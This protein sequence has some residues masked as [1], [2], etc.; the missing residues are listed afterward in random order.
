MKKF[1]LRD[2]V[3]LLTGASSGIGAALALELGRRGARLAL[4]SRRLEELRKVAGQAQAAGSPEAIALRLDVEER[5]SCET[6]VKMATKAFDRVDC[7]VNNAG[8]HLFSQVESLPEEWLLKAFQTNVLGPMRLIQTVT[9]Q[10]RNQGSGLIVQISSTLSLRSLPEVGGYAATKA[11]LNRL[12]ESLRMELDGSGIG[13]LNVLPGV[14]TTPLRA[15]SLHP[16]PAPTDHGLPFPRT[17]ELTAREI[18]DA[19]EA[20]RR[21]LMSCAWQ[22]K[23]G[24]KWLSVIAPGFQDKRFKRINPVK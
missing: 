4:G 22:V 24:M 9:P 17:A 20:G 2:K 14:V 8:T 7:L 19:M 21:D 15:H 1:P 23:V 11:A 10:M 18:A 3:V 5:V 6:F 16:G 12:T 13:V